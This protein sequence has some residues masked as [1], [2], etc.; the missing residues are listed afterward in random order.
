MDSSRW[1][2]QPDPS[3]A[4]SRSLPG[5]YTISFD[6][7]DKPPYR[8]ALILVHHDDGEDVRWAFRWFVLVSLLLHGSLLLL[9]IKDPALLNRLEDLIAPQKPP[10]TEAMRKKL[11]EERKPVFVDLLDPSKVPKADRTIAPPLPKGHS[12]SGKPKAHDEKNVVRPSTTPMPPKVTA[13]KPRTTPA[14]PEAE[15]PLARNEPGLR[16]VKKTSRHDHPNHKKLKEHEKQPVRTAQN[17]PESPSEKPEKSNKV[18]RKISPKDLQKI[19]SEESLG[20]PLTKNLHLSHDLSPAYSDKPD[21]TDRIM[22][23][24]E[25]ETYSSYIKRIQERFETIGEYPEAAAS[26]GI[27]GRVLVTFTILADGTLDSASLSQSSGSAILDEEALRIVRVASPYI[28]LPTA[29]HKK[30]LT[31]TWAFIFYNG[32]FHV[33]Q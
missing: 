26:R 3:C 29:F 9:M 19:L 5:V 18:T 24:L 1:E 21:P 31:L 25:D 23:N 2:N 15:A 4:L 14:S 30:Q 32:G 20:D 7:T 8:Q 28:P 17:K 16:Q 13:Q 33:I 27:T 10:M 6:S 11:Q 22:A 12:L